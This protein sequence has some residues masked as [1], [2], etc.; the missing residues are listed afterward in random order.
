MT[1]ERLYTTRRDFLTGSISFLSAASTMP[2][3]LGNTARV[4]AGPEPQQKRRND[5]DRIL[6]VVQLAGGND[7][8]NTIVPYEADPYYKLRQRLA[9]PKKDV[10]KLEQG[11]G[12]HPAATG[13]KE[14]YDDGLMA[15][16]QG[17]G[18]PNP[19]RS[20]FSS[21]DIWN[22]A[23]PTLK[24]H[25]GWLGRYFDACCSGS[26]PAPEP[27]EG[28]ALMGEAPLAMQGDRFFPLSF[29][30]PA[31][32]AWKAGQRN[33]RANDVFRK[34]NNVDSEMPRGGS[35]LAQFLQRAALKAQLGADEIHAVAG[36]RTGGA[37]NRRGGRG[38]QLGRSLDL[39]ARMIAA[40][41]PTRIYY[42]SMGGFDTH[43]GQDNRHRQ[44]MTQLSSG[45]KSF[46]DTLKSNKQLD[47]VLVLTFSEFGRRV[48]PNASGGTDH[49]EAA[50]M[51]LFGSQ[52]RPGIHQKHP[53][54]TKLHR[55]DLS[56]G[57]DFR[58]VYAAVLQNWL[59]MRP[60]KVLGRKFAPLKVIRA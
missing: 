14:L 8:L 43:T 53:N 5:S 10:L 17:V 15:V 25:D 56:F 42:V 31:A 30:N 57:C 34:L 47:R 38:G 22:T 60:E 52:V 54:L 16:V 46:F 49:G 59:K 29:S 4:L 3:F 36:R 24:M 7:G 35:E 33:K 40:D 44:L 39:V 45:M 18:Y 37:A 32:L 12:L 20:H 23:D 28:V 6:V 51:F 9:I 21:M 50:P 48:Q 41:M 2:V 58:R 26:D 13:F 19:N 55:G 11:L 27:I 1:D